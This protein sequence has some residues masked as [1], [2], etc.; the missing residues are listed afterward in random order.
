M[1]LLGAPGVGKG[2]QAK[3]L[4]A[5]FA[6]PQISTGDLLRQHR[7][8]H[9][10]LGMMADEL[11]QQGKLVPDDLVNQ[12]VAERLA[13]ADCDRGYILD[14][15]PRTLAQAAWLDDYLERTESAW[16]VVVISIRVP[17]DDLL[18]RITGRRICPD[19]HIYNI[20]TQPPRV[21][22]IC[23]VDGKALTQR[24]DDTEA[25]FEQRMKEFHELT[26]PVV[27]HYQ[28]QGRFA[29]VDGLR[30]VDEVTEAIRTELERLRAQASESIETAGNR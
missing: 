15:F 6:I 17:Y 22:G 12:M 7:R 11:M 29:E 30:S 26:A 21:E 20:Y 4:M 28:G 10:P 13:Q 24:N 23:D 14:G 18:Q 2:T 27:P 25:A 5:E 19:G 1:L 8:E 3:V 16:P 9:T